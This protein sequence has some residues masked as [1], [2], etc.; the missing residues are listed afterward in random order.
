MVESDGAG[1]ALSLQ[2]AHWSRVV[3]SLR[4]ALRLVFFVSIQKSLLCTN[5]V[6]R[7]HFLLLKWRAEVGSPLCKV[8]WSGADEQKVQTEAHSVSFPPLP[9]NLRK[10]G[11]R[12]Q[13]SVIVPQQESS[14]SE[15]SPLGKK[16]PAERKGLIRMASCC[17]FAELCLTLFLAAAS[18]LFWPGGF[19]WRVWVTTGRLKSGS[20]SV[21][22]VKVLFACNIPAAKAL[23]KPNL[24]TRSLSSL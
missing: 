24:V 20:A 10:S 11:R 8:W 14:A 12:S 19:A 4:G 21:N 6:A 5:G 22:K 2:E 9:A 15:L 13:A 16:E 18:V 17:A 1:A 3:R 7:V 23:E